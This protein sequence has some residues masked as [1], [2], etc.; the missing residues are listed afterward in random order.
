[1]QPQFYKYQATGND[2]ILVDNRQGHWPRS[3]Q[4]LYA[5]LCHRQF[6]IGADGLILIQNA[7]VDAEGLDFEMVY[8]NADGNPGSMCGNGGRAAVVF[9]HKLGMIQTQARF[10][11][12]DGVHTAYYNVSAGL[13]KLK[14]GVQSETKKVGDNA[15]FVNTGSPHY[16][17]FLNTAQDVV[18]KDYPVLAEGRRIRYSQQ[19]LP[20]GTNVNFVEMLLD[21]LSVR[22]YERGVEDETLSCGTGVTA[23]ALV[24]ASQVL[25]QKVFE[26]DIETPG[27]KLVVCRNEE[28]E[29]FLIGPAEEVYSGTLAANATLVSL[30]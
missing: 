21:R 5:T 18:L 3:S 11:A 23:C 28:D 13:V 22:T 19:F 24:Y 2:F 25:K 6:G 7:V 15:F 29:V 26:K 30:F 20:H 16:V 10:L 4:H 17:Q 8:F 9:A 1:M 12:Y 27:G 14:M